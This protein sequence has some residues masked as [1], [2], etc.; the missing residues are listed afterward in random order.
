MI[1]SL[2]IIIYRSFT[3]SIMNSLTRALLYSA[4]LWFFAEGMLGPL[5]AVF[6]QQI[7]GD[8]LE[9]SWAWATYLIIMG[10][11]IFLVGNLSDKQ[12]MKERLMLAGFALNAILTFC[13][14]LI[15]NPFQLLVLQGGI[16]LATALAYPTWDALYARYASKKHDG[17]AWSIADGGNNMATGIGML[18]G[19]FII[20]YFSF[21]A[22]FV[23]M[24]A[25]QLTGAVIA[26]VAFNK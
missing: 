24:G 20:S 23:I 4:Y 3:Q 1:G 21:T 12:H 11:S 26:F 22:L 10:A 17:L 13:Y 9:I 15:N 18:I 8:V 5:F 7:G 2:E 6:S 25:L 14:L 16:G 19:G